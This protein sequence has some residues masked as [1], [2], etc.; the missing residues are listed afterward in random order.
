MR[1][2]TTLLDASRRSRHGRPPRTIDK[3]G[4]EACPLIYSPEQRTLRWLRNIAPQFVCKLVPH[5][6]HHA[7]QRAI[8]RVGHKRSFSGTRKPKRVDKRE[9]IPNELSARLLL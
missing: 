4:N 7:I 8:F 6:E 1:L 5:Q 9:P 3:R 2:G